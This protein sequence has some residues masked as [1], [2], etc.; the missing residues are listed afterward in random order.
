M[1]SRGFAIVV[2]AL[3]LLAG[4]GSAAAAPA[5]KID[6]IL[7]EKARHLLTLYAEGKAVKSYRVAIGVG[8]PGNKERRGDDRT[9]EG[10]YVIDAK[11]PRSEFH[12][13]LHISYPSAADRQ[14][15]RRRGVRVGGMIAI[16]GTPAFIERM[17]DAGEHP[18]WT[19]GCIGVRNR[20]M[21]E[22]Y[23]LVAVG[24]PIE[25]KP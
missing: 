5:A 21:D 12:R 14:A 19:A 13:A 10:S 2:A 24:T 16:H 4:A 17:Q 25:I 7:V 9:P 1:R 15:A 20:E 23:E 22:I 11:N 18:D 6:R 3:S 8:P